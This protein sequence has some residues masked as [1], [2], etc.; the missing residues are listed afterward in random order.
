MAPSMLSGLED[1]NQDE[2]GTEREGS[3]G[4][5]KN[6]AVFR[7]QGMGQTVY[8]RRKSSQERDRGDRWQGG[9]HQ[10]VKV[11]PL[12]FLNNKL[13]SCED[14]ERGRHNHHPGSP[15]PRSLDRCSSTQPLLLRTG[16]LQR[17]SGP[18]C[19]SLQSCSNII[20]SSASKPLSNLTDVHVACQAIHFDS[21]SPVNPP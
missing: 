20:S 13:G 10:N 15:L 17:G 16:E 7:K 3:G 9:K 4:G 6:G 12:I 5:T 1:H 21:Q 19:N 11:A 8:E 18:Q 14:C 2:H